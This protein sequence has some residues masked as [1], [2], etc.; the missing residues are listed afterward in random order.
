[1]ILFAGGQAHAQTTPEIWKAKCKSCHGEGG[2]AETKTGK[3]E[4]IADMR[5]A[6]FQ[7]EWSDEEMVKVI[8][9]GS[10][11]NRKMKPFEDKLSPENIEDLIKLIRGFRADGAGPK[12]AA[13]PPPAPAEP[14]AP[15]APTPPPT[16]VAP[17]ITPAKPSA[18][19]APPPTIPEKPPVPSPPRADP[20]P[21]PPT[22]TPVALAPPPP[23][24][25][26]VSPPPVKA[27]PEP[28]AAPASEPTGTGNF[29]ITIASIALSIVALIVALRR[30][31]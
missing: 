18:P 4:K 22:P 24:D 12:V 30:K 15:V 25:V 11:D 13:A 31:R 17:P 14:P 9:R 2:G 7:A 10:P 8:K 5:T 23:P 19:G 29:W 27:A 3:S 6:A 1:M 21:P 26:P 16:P 20:I 28:I